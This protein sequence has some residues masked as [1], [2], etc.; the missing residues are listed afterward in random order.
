M[1]WK[2]WQSPFW[3]GANESFLSVQLRRLLHQLVFLSTDKSSVVEG[4]KTFQGERLNEYFQVVTYAM[5]AC[6]VIL[7]RADQ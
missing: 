3:Q 1:S 5:L 6:E 7:Q 2:S 4:V